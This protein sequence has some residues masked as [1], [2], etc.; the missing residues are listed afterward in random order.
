LVTRWYPFLDHFS[1]VF[2]LDAIPS[3]FG[4]SV[5]SLPGSFICDDDGCHAK[6]LTR[7]VSVLRLDSVCLRTLCD[8]KGVRLKVT[9][10]VSILI[11]MSRTTV[12]VVFAYEMLSLPFGLLDPLPGLPGPQ[13]YV[14][15][16]DHG[17]LG[18][19]FGQVC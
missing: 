16:Q 13:C 12:S 8:E 7:M 2:V 5:V 14:Y 11:Y 17:A 9:R 6:T 4:Y 10:R 18:N 19:V 15:V 3:T 1:V